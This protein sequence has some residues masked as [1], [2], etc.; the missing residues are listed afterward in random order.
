M[1]YI[2]KYVFGLLQASSVYNLNIALKWIK[3]INWETLES[4]L[5]TFINSFRRT[6]VATGY[7]AHQSK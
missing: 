1:K 4:S 6:V 2:P 5:S 7:S 3:N